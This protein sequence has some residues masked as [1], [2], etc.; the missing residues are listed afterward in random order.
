MELQTLLGESRH[1]AK[2]KAAWLNLLATFQVELGA[3]VETVT[4]T[5]R[6]ILDDFPGTPAAEIAARRLARVALEFKGKQPTA[7]VKLGEYE[8]NIGLKYGRPRQ[9]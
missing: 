6:K 7:S 9:P 8:Q 3:D 1:V 5:L 2:Q 4:A